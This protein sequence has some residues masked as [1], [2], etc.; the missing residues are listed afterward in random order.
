METS[1]IQCLA[2]HSY[3]ET[4]GLWD[5]SKPVVGYDIFLSHTWLT[6]GRRV[7]GARTKIQEHVCM[8]SKPK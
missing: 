4:R 3:Q 6:D 2:P 8:V 5:Q 7:S 1:I